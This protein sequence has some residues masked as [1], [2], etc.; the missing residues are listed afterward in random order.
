M[1][2]FQAHNGSCIAL[3]RDIPRNGD[4]LFSRD[5]REFREMEVRGYG[6]LLSD[7][8]ITV[9]DPLTDEKLELRCQGSVMK[10]DSVEFYERPLEPER[11]ISL[12]TIRVPH[13]LYITSDRVVVYVSV[14]KYHPDYRLFVGRLGAP[15]YDLPAVPIKSF[16]RMRDGGTTTIGSPEGRLYVPTHHHPEHEA[17]WNDQPLTKLDPSCVLVETA[18]FA[19]LSLA[20]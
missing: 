8:K 7:F 15:P 9:V 10:Y 12:P 6:G 14:D 4:V 11:V 20:V 3:R 5:G 18:D 13:Y 1:R 16:T 2:V 19:R 17:L